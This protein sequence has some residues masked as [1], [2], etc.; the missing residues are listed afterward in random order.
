MQNRKKI[1]IIIILLTLFFI[2]SFILSMTISTERTINMFWGSFALLFCGILLDINKWS[3]IGLDVDKNNS[4]TIRR[5]FDDSTTV[6]SVFIGT[7]TCIVVFFDTF[8][9]NIMKNN[10][11]IITMFIM[12]LEYEL[13]SYLSIWNAKKDTA[14]LLKKGK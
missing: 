11:V 6:S 1:R 5:S 10:Y 8:S 13:F 3:K 14:T 12:T 4:R 7:L 9:H 2:T